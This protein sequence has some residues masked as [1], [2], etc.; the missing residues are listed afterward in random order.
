M[1]SLVA[2]SKGDKRSRLLKVK[3]RRGC[4]GLRVGR[5]VEVYRGEMRRRPI[6]GTERYMKGWLY[7]DGC[8]TVRLGWV[9]V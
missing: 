9:L 8:F 6:I 2:A 3:G 1:H 4:Q 7:L 5:V